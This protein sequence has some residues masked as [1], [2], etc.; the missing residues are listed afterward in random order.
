MALDKIYVR[1]THIYRHRKEEN[2]KERVRVVNRKDANVY[3][4][5]YVY[6]VNK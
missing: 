3:L 2:K 6:Y 5:I 1:H 4:L